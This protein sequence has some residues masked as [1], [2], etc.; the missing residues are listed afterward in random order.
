LFSN[1]RGKSGVSTDY[2]E[3]WRA[4][5]APMED[6]YQR[7]TGHFWF[8]GRNDQEEVGAIKEKQKA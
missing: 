4:L 3:A 6:A 5:F 1:Y 2:A 7:M 8:L